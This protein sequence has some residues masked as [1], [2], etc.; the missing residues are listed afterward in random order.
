MICMLFVGLALKIDV[1]KMEQAFQTRY[2]KGDKV[3]YV[4]PLNWKGEEEFIDSYVDSWNAHY[5]SKNDIFD[6][7]FL[8]EIRISSFFKGRCFL[9]ATATIGLT[10]LTSNVCTMKILNGTIQWTL[11]GLVELFTAMTNRNK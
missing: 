8:L 2:H 5:R 10:C 11:H 9:C 7:T 3:F 4:S 1:L 6:L